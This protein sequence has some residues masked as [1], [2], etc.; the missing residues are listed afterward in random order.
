ME[1]GLIDIGLLLEP[2]DIGKFDFIRLTGKERWVVLMRPGDPLAEKKWITAKDL[3]GLPVILPHRENVRNEVSSW[4]GESYGKLNVLFT[5][6]LS[7]NGAVM[8]R[9]GLGYSIVI[10][11]AVPFWDEKM[12]V[13]RPLY[14]ELYSS[15]VVAWK[16]QQPFSL[17]VTRFIEE[18][19]CFSGMNKL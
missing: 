16:K 2:I 13:Y 6:N 4:F 10:E 14:P 7:T 3:E 5:S 8:V 15:C 11:G 9:G 17:A 18:I 19:R 1:K 12:T